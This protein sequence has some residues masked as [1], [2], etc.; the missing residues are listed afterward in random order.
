MTRRAEVEFGREVCGDLGAAEAREWLVTNGIGGFASGTIAGS[1]TRRYHG[2]LIAALQPPLGR[3]QLVSTMD[4]TLRY[5]GAEYPLATHRWA[6]GAMEPSGF[7]YIEKFRLEDTTPVWTFALA[8]A[9][10]S[11]AIFAAGID[12]TE[13][14]PLP[15]DHELY[16]LPNC[17]IAPHIASATHDTRDAMATLCAANLLAGIR[18]ERLPN[19]V[20]PSVYG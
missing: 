7:R 6:S 18:G 16:K 4:E 9:L 3:T 8:D 17:V 11:G 19:C 13:P 10:R 5:G 12:V 2:L 14:E 20:N 15:A 1:L